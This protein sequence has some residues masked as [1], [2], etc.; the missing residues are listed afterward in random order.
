M[1]PTIISIYTSS[2][3]LPC[4]YA[5]ISVHLHVVAASGPACLA[6]VAL[7]ALL[8]QYFLPSI[9]TLISFGRRQRPHFATKLLATYAAF[10][11]F[12]LKLPDEVTAQVI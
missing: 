6:I 9:S 1:F 8:L 7:F 3:S 11:V 4:S 12:F 5:A 10:A 2:Q